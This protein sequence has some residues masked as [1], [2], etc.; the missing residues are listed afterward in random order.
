MNA[1]AHSTGFYL[2]G[3]F[4]TKIVDSKGKE[5]GFVSVNVPRKILSIDGRETGYLFGGALGEEILDNRGAPTG[6]FVGGP[7]GTELLG[8]S[9]ELSDST[10]T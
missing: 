10:R 8:P 5:I 1:A 4:E 7:L 3:P 9:S 6:F 2:A